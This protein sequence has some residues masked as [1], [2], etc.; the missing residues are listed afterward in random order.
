MFGLALRTG[1][2]MRVKGVYL[3]R[4]EL[5]DLAEELGVSTRDVLTKDSILTVYNT[6]KASQE[7]IDDD[8]LALCIAMALNISVEAITEMTE[9]KEEPIKMDFDLSDFEDDDD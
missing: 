4:P 8:D 5:H 9:V 7:I 3:T 1:F 2:S 6:T